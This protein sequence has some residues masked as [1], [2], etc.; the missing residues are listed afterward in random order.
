MSFPQTVC[1]NN[2]NYS[3]ISM[4]KTVEQEKVSK[5]PLARTGHRKG[6]RLFSSSRGERNEI[7]KPYR[8]CITTR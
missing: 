8:S 2:F 7:M 3:D 4:P 6:G 5:A 1:N